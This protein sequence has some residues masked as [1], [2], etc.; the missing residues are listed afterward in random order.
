MAVDGSIAD[1]TAER[2]TE[3]TWLDGLA[4]TTRADS[5]GLAAAR[6][7][8]ANAGTRAARILDRS[9]AAFALD[10]AGQRKGATDALVRLEWEEAEQQWFRGDG[11]DHPFVP[12]VDRLMAARWLSAAGDLAQAARLLK[13]NEAIYPRPYCGADPF[14]RV[15]SPLTSL[16]Q[17]RVEDARGRAEAA[18]VYYQEFLEQ[19]DMPVAAHRHLVDDARRAVR[20]IV[21][22]PPP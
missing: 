14:E 2:R 17:G 10:L 20:R 9:L 21:G 3:A 19:Y 1:L 5:R 18:R 8:L 4:A 7:A 13:W 12:A 11:C 15:L 22:E 6:Q 16:E